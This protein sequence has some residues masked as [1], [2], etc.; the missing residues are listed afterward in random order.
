M[1]DLGGALIFFSVL[2]DGEVELFLVEQI[3][4]V[5]QISVLGVRMVLVGLLVL[6]H[7]SQ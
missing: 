5:L 3:E 1:G 4:D 2:S 6:V 7:Q